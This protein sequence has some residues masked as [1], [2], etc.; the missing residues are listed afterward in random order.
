MINFFPQDK[1]VKQ[2]PRNGDILFDL[3][4]LMS[5]YFCFALC[6]YKIARISCTNK[7]YKNNK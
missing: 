3:A 4:A 6:F 7:K 5:L 2:T 1:V